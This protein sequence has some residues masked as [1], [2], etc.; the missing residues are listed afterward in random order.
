MRQVMLK[1]SKQKIP[2]R[3]NRIVVFFIHYLVLVL[4]SPYVLISCWVKD[5]K[6]FL[7]K[8]KKI[9][10]IRIDGLGDVTLSTPVFKA[11][12]DI[13]PHAEITLLV[14]SWSKELVE[15]MP[16][17]DEVIYLDVPWVVKNKKEKFSK[18]IKVIKKVRKRRF[19]I[20]MDLRGDFRN[21]ILMYLFKGKYRIGYNTTGCQFLL[22]HV[23]SL[24]DN[25]H[26]INMGQSLIKYLKPNNKKKY[27]PSLWIEEKDRIF[28]ENF[29]SYNGVKNDDLVV[30][31]H[32]AARWDGRQWQIEGYANIADRLIEK[33]GVKVVFT[34]SINDVKLTVKIVKQMKNIPI[35]A[36]GKN[37]LKQFLA[38]LEKCNLFIGVDSGPMHM[39]AALGIQV[40]ALFG[41]ARVEAMRPY[42]NGHII[43]TQQDSFSCSPCAQTFCKRPKNSCMKAITIDMVWTAVEKQI[44]KIKLKEIKFHED[45]T[46]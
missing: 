22:T 5:K 45:T 46:Y 34:G 36:T 3:K 17:F 32:P 11:L 21:N 10:I 40:I 2:V 25:H 1:I 8:I 38:L 12:R 28:S 42:G 27:E 4:F 39:A 24:G 30:I 41:A 9:L 20:T 6:I 23:V 43:L 19:D 13:F 44:E 26:P 15:G 29:L 31:M 16:T 18:L 14:A 35:I 33:Y 7:K 37:N